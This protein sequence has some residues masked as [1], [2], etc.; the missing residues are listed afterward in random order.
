MP[1]MPTLAFTCFIFF[2]N[3]LQFLREH[4]LLLFYAIYNA[5]IQLFFS[6]KLSLGG[7]R[8]MHDIDTCLKA[9]TV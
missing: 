9:L 7:L 5:F 8:S 6:T 3:H 1:P 4:I 2:P